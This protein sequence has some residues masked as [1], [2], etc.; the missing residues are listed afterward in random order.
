MCLNLRQVHKTWQ[1]WPQLGH[2]GIKDVRQTWQN[3]ELLLLADLK[4]PASD[5]KLYEWG[6]VA[7]YV[8]FMHQNTRI[9]ALSG[10]QV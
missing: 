6:E 9:Q 3:A 1:L 5:H 7:L 10:G 8:I 2:G 4:V